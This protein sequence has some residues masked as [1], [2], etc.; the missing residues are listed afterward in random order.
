MLVAALGLG[1][2]ALVLVL[3]LREQRGGGAQLRCRR[4]GRL[5]LRTR[6]F[7]LAGERGELRAQADELRFGLGLL[8]ARGIALADRDFRALMRRA[9]AA[10][11]VLEFRVHA[12]ER[13]AQTLRLKA[14]REDRALAREAS[15]GD[16]AA[17][18]D[19]LAAK[20]DDRVAKTA[21]ANELDSGLKLVDD[22]HVADQEAHDS[23]KPRRG[24]DERVRVAQDAGDGADRR[25]E[26]ASLA[27]R[28][29]VE[30]QER[31][32]AGLLPIQ[33]VRRRARHPPTSS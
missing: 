13:V 16:R 30:R 5:Q 6:A 14:P 3:A 25:I 27:V 9:Q 11:G 23:G 29:R 2:G 17:A 10:L 33:E 8:A 15:A 26:L 1:L 32:A 4:A 7:D 31:G 22:Q 19:L 18:G 24:A 21:P 20:R 28:Q 12:D